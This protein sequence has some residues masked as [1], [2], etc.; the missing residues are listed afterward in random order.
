MIAEGP[1]MSLLL[2]LTGPNAIMI[3][4]SFCCCIVAI[5]L[6]RREIRQRFLKFSKWIDRICGGLLIALGVRLAITKI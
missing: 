4:F 2:D 5:I 1:L 3:L 6:N